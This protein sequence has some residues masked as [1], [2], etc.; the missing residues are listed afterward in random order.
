MVSCSNDQEDNL[1]ED[2]IIHVNKTKN[3]NNSKNKKVLETN[4]RYIPNRM[5]TNRKSMLILYGI[6]GIV[7]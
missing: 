5:N 2:E 4:Y 1:I 6:N 7:N 3:F